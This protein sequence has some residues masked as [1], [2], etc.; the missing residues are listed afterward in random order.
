[1]KRAPLEGAPV[2]IDSDIYWRPGAGVGLAGGRVAVSGGAGLRR[3][4]L[5]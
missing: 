2:H 3:S 4:V 5:V 1:M